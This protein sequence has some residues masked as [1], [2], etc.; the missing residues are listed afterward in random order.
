MSRQ[1]V[2]VDFP[3]LGSV[4]SVE[5]GVRRLRRALGGTVE[6]YRTLSE[7]SVREALETS[8]FA[9]TR[10]HRQFVLPINFHKLFN[11]LVVTLAIERA[12]AAVG[13]LAL[14]GSPVTFV[15]TRREPR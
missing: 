2:I 10:V 4:A 3:A 14:F 11:S 6:A 7:A 8:G 9:V 13:C 12:L 15:A 5:A 1:T